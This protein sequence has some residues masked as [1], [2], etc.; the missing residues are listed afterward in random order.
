MGQAKL[1]VLC[2]AGKNV[3][4]PRRPSRS[5]TP[6][7]SLPCISV[8]FSLSLNFLLPGSEA[9]WY[10][11]TSA[12]PPPFWP[13]PPFPAFLLSHT[14]VAWLFHLVSILGLT[15]LLHLP[16]LP[17]CLF[18]TTLV[19]FLPPMWL[20]PCLRTYLAIRCGSPTTGYYPSRIPCTRTRHP[21][22]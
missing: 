15:F 8:S 19:G 16:M 9:L 20:A 5:Q 14:V 2:R 3:N 21:L 10:Y 22:T 18:Q 17:T 7:H 6:T 1:K 12:F 4:Q 11:P 13:V